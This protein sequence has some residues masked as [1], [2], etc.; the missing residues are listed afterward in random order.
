M[1]NVLNG[2]LP[3][4]GSDNTSV[5]PSQKRLAES[6]LQLALQIESEV[7]ALITCLFP[8]HACYFITQW[9]VT[10]V[11]VY[12]VDIDIIIGCPQRMPWCTLFLEVVP[13]LY[14]HFTAIYYDVN[15]VHDFAVATILA[16]FQLHFFIHSN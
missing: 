9:L 13:L 1:S 5:N 4:S 8:V 15:L 3:L 2:L 7:F 10:K 11:I 6:M 14:I 12:S 16:L